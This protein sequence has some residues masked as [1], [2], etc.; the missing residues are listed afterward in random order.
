MAD[1]KLGT[2]VGGSVVWHQGNF[3]LDPV[4]N[5]LYY[6]TY[7]IYSEWNK[8]KAIDN[9]FVSK[10][11]GGIYAGSVSFD[12]GLNIKDKDGY[13]INFGKNTQ[14]G[15]M[16][17]YSARMKVKDT[18]AYETDEGQPFILFN[19]TKD[20]N[21]PRLTV[22]GNISGRQLFEEGGRVYSVGNKPTPSEVGLGNVSNDAQVKINE[23]QTQTMKGPLIA[24]MLSTQAEATEP[25]QVPQLKQVIL[26]GVI[27]D[28]GKY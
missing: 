15:A 19:P 6:K 7:K 8:P 17:A 18:F 21:T 16:F 22:M 5:D 24:T 4:S 14:T 2:T 13:Q 20:I 23:T 11:A 25:A 26:K 28:F 27:I 1:L 12:A 3:P 10:A 9:D